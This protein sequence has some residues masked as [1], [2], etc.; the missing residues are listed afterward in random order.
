MFLQEL[1][2]CNKSQVHMYYKYLPFKV[3]TIYAV[4]VDNYYIYLFIEAWLFSLSIPSIVPYQQS[5]YSPRKTYAFPRIYEEETVYWSAG[6]RT[7]QGDLDR[8]FRLVVELL[9]VSLR[10][11]RHDT[12]RHHETTGLMRHFQSLNSLWVTQNDYIPS[13]ITYHRKRC[14]SNLCLVTLSTIWCGLV[15]TVGKRD[16][17]IPFSNLQ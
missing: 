13:T 1:P 12:P 17:A 9:A 10:R 3:T 6:I 14:Q 16:G 8:F 7:W 4:C 11:F 5:L 15:A 2:T